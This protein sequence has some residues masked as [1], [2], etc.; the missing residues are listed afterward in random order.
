MAV[1]VL[2][3]ALGEGGAAARVVY[4]RLLRPKVRSYLVFCEACCGSPEWRCRAG[5]GAHTGPQAS[6]LHRG[7]AQEHRALG[8]GLVSLGLGMA[9][10]GLV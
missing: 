2:R 1:A 5:A 10:V 6:A 7:S 8:V 4:V 9:L 3:A